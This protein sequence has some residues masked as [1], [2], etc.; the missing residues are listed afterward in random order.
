MGL[1]RTRRSFPSLATTDVPGSTPFTSTPCLLADLLGDVLSLG[2]R[3]P[4]RTDCA[5]SK[6]VQARHARHGCGKVTAEIRNAKRENAIHMSQYLTSDPPPFPPTD[7]V[8]NNFWSSTVEKS[9]N[10]GRHPTT[11]YL[12]GRGEM[13]EARYATCCPRLIGGSG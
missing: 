3:R 11:L 7:K 12:G 8:D 13:S 5:T 9:S 2:P 10:R 4:Q 1:Q 6:S